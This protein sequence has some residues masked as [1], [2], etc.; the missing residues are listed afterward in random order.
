MAKA[1]ATGRQGF[2]QHRR[3]H[4]R[5]QLQGRFP[6]QLPPALEGGEQLGQFGGGAPA[7][8]EEVGEEEAQPFRPGPGGRGLTQLPQPVAQPGEQ[9]Q[10]A[11][12]ELQWSAAG[13]WRGG[14]FDAGRQSRAGGEHQPQ[15]QP[16][17]RPAEGMGGVA[18][19]IPAVE[20]PAES[21]ALQQFVES[22]SLLRRELEALQEGAAGQHP[23]QTGGREPGSTELQ[24]GQEAAA[25]PPFGLL[26][27]VRQPPGQGH[28]GGLAVAE[29]GAHQGREPIHLGG[30]HQDVAG[31]Q[32]GV[33]GHQLQQPVANDLHL[34]EGTGAGVEF[35]GVVG[36]VPV[37]PPGD[38]PCGQLILELV[39]Q[40]GDIRLRDRG[41]AQKQI[42]L[43]PG[44]ELHLTGALQQLLEFG[45][46]P[47][48]AGFQG[49]RLQQ[50]VGVEG[51]G[52]REGI[53][54]AKPAG[55]AAFPEVR[56]G[57]EQVEVHRLAATEGLQ[58]AHLHRGQAAQAEES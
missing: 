37:H 26:A 54:E 11:A 14:G 27:S 40:G 10:P 6:C 39:E 55:G 58:Q 47:S 5:L 29:H 22:A 9:V 19:A 32:A 45:P 38:R 36:F 7:I 50:P 16:V 44:T 51:I 12:A 53:A 23:L 17:D 21:C 4:R 46:E 34:P 49:R 35:Q 57:G 8:A 33:G 48:E 43:P 24:Q 15:Q 25:D 1:A 30:H 42:V 20:P 31:L 13:G 28:P 41:G 18:A 52:Q 3:S 2:L 56:T